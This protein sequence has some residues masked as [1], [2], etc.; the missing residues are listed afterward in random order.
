MIIIVHLLKVIYFILLECSEVKLHFFNLLRGGK[1]EKI[2]FQV[3]TT[4][5][6]MNI[7]YSYVSSCYAIMS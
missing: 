3:K 4:F 6:E 7:P 2:A 5:N 1:F